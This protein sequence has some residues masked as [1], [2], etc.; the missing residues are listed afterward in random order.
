MA[1]GASKSL[2]ITTRVNITNATIRNVANATSDT[3]G[4]STPGNNSTVVDPVANITVVKLVS[5]NVTKTG[6]V[7]TWTVIVTNNGPDVSVN[8][9]VTDKLPAGL[10]YNGHHADM[11]NYDHESGLWIIGDMANGDVKKLV[12]STIV[13]ITNTTIKN[14]ANVTSDTPGDKTNG[15]NNTTSAP[16]ADLVV[17]KEVSKSQVEYGEM[18]IWIIT[19]T[20]KGPDKAVNVIVND[21]L[22][23][24]LV[25]LY[26]DGNYDNNT[27]IWRVGDL[28]LGEHRSLRIWTLVNISNATIRN[29]ANSTSDTLE[30][31]LLVIILLLLILLL[32]WK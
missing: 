29:V 3:P 8:T 12:I 19:V 7:I 21:T 28:N 5:A 9:R 22:P 6:D 11:G 26:D 23:N 31:V 15:T 24:G 17:V 30:T 25:Y 14:V 27:G 10:I 1:N 2:V 13:N 18:I 16:K 20:N 4:N 32:I